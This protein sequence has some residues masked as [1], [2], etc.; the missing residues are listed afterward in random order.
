M[1]WILDDVPPVSGTF[2]AEYDDIRLSVSVDG[3]QRWTHFLLSFAAFSPA[4]TEERKTTWPREAIEAA[5][6]KL[7]KFERMLECDSTGPC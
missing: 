7:D 4:T 3:E 6:L 2:V 5:R 1:N